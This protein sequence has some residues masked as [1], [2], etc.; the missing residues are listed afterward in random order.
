MKSN[1]D[2]TE[3]AMSVRKNNT[4]QKRHFLPQNETA[5]FNVMTIMAILCIMFQVDLLFQVTMWYFAIKSRSLCFY[6][7]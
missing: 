5:V 7:L 6:V 2:V 3:T 1:M 4:R